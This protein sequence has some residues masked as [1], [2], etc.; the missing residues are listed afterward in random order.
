MRGSL[1][2]A[3]FMPYL[4]DFAA[5][6]TDDSA[7]H[8]Q[9]VGVETMTSRQFNLS[10]P[11]FAGATPSLHMDV[12]RLIA[13]EARE[14]EPIRSRDVLD[15]WHSQTPPPATRHGSLGAGV[16]DRRVAANTR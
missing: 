1:L 15:P 12:R 9:F 7:N 2:L 4:Q 3:V 14:E 11:E 6:R 10:E 16:L 5:L 8:V 13:V